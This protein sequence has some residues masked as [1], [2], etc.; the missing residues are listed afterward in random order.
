MKDDR[1]VRVLSG[2][3]IAAQVVFVLA[4][5]VAGV[6][7]RPSYSSLEH[8]ISDM[9]AEDAPHAWLLVVVFTVCGLLTMAFALVVVPRTLAGAGAWRWVCALLLAISIIALG[10]ALSAF[11][12]E[13]CQL[14][15][16]GCSTADQMTG[17][18]TADAVLSTIGLLVLIPLGFFF[19]AAFRRVGRAHLVWPA[20]IASLVLVLLLLLTGVAPAVDLG[21]LLERLLAAYVA[22]CVAALAWVLGF[23]NR[24]P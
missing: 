5:L 9:Y 20:R 7:Q 15:T 19:A 11:E 3:C 23:S 14:A 4:W 17:G 6:W 22:A 18:G 21:G 1:V 10:D 16:R 12:Q 2:A 8:T 13:G 24:T